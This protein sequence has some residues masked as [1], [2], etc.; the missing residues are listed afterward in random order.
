MPRARR[1][2]WVS[3]VVVAGVML[4]VWL[5]WLA[6]RWGY[7]W[8]QFGNMG[9]GLAAVEHGVLGVYAL[10]HEELPTVRGVVVGANGVAGIVEQRIETPPNYPPLSMLALWAQAWV[11]SRVLVPLEVNTR[12]ARLLGAVVPG[13]GE[14]LVLWGIVGLVRALGGGRH[15]I[16]VGASAG[17]LF[18]PLA[19]NAWFWGQNDALVLAPAVGAVACMARGRWRASGALVAVAALV[20]P[21]GVLLAVP[22]LFA[23]AAG[24]ERAAAPRRLATVLVSGALAVLVLTAPWMATSGLAWVGRSYLASA[25]RYSQA[26]LHAYNVW[27]LDA[28]LHGRVL[29]GSTSLAGLARDTWGALL[30]VLAAVAAG[31]LA[32]RRPSAEAGVLFAALWVWSAF[33]WPTRVH[34]RYVLYCAPLVIALAAVRPRFWPCVVGL[35][36]VGVGAH[37]WNVW[38]RAP[39]PALE[40]LLTATSLASYAW[41]MVAASVPGERA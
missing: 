11:S 4:R 32:W 18:P 34:E 14:V 19:L 31:V 7:P 26:T 21:Q 13:I 35:A 24:G 38:Q 30:L 27:Y 17:W 10:R 23:A 9:M 16:A 40:W 8:D 36:L 37:T 12:G 5:L 25:A 3:G 33:L 2:G 28:L 15:A 41:A 29:D 20:K 6:P 22:L 1:L 39:R